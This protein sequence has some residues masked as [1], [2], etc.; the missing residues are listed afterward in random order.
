MRRHEKAVQELS[1]I[2]EIIRRASVCHLGLAQD[3]QPY[4]VPMSFGY[5]SRTVYFHAAREGKKLD[6]LRQNPRVCVEFESDVAVARKEHG[7]AWTMRYRSVIGFG[8]AVIIED[9]RERFEALQLIMRQYAGDASPS[10][11][12]PAALERT[13]LFKVELDDITGKVSGYP[14]E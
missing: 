3:G 6:I 4:V 10:D 12:S 14:K 2:E 13:L 11:F 1:G 5:R 8:K 9:E 7:C